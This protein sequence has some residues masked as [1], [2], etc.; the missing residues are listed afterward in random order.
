M[1]IP[2]RSTYK[3]DVF[4]SSWIG[5]KFS[6]LGFWGST[7]R[8][9]WLFVVLAGLIA[10]DSKNLT[11]VSESTAVDAL[12]HVCNLT[13][14]LCRVD[15]DFAVRIASLLCQQEQ[16]SCSDALAWAFGA[17]DRI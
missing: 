12:D 17:G 10:I 2:K 15:Y 14:I 6:E 8:E 9:I 5:A 3:D 16:E 1:Y 11:L 7:A 4:A 13:P